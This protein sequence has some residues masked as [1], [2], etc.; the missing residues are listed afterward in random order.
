MRRS[1]VY[2]KSLAQGTVLSREDVMFKRPGTG[3]A[4]TEV[5][6]IVG[7]TLAEPVAEDTFV[8]PAHFSH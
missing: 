2:R 6:T 4:P 5:D 8:C 7:K 3:I 1:V